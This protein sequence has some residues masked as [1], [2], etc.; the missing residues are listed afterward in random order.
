M[1]RLKEKLRGAHIRMWAGFFFFFL[2]SVV[3]VA[4]QGLDITSGWSGCVKKQMKKKKRG[5]EPISCYS[6]WHKD[7]LD[8]LLV[9]IWF[10]RK[11]A[12]G[13]M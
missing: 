5:N 2:L 8:L 3:V 6:R 1:N 12:D 9:D 11:E 13:Q 10:E 7:P 4:G